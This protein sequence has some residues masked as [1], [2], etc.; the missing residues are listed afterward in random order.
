MEEV[1]AT[2]VIF[3]FVETDFSLCS[4]GCPEAN[5]YVDQAGLK[6]EFCLP[7]PL[8]CWIKGKHHH[9]QPNHVFSTAALA[10]VAVRELLL[11][12]SDECPNPLLCLPMIA[13][14]LQH[15]QASLQLHQSRHLA[16]DDV[17]GDGTKVFL[18]YLVGIVLSKN[19]GFLGCPFPIFWQVRVS[20]R[21]TFLHLLHLLVKVCQP[22]PLQ[23]WH[24]W[25][26]KTQGTR[27]STAFQ[28]LRCVVGLLPA[29]RI[30]HLFN[31]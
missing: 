1:Q 4:P 9:T 12:S 16:F 10:L 18:S 29:P 17:V 27:Y 11:T 28:V 22:I 20:V 7:L 14:S 26:K 24:V 23:I 2:H 3:L 8:K 6:L 5:N 30:L 21:W 15:W 31:P 25:G 13:S 19:C